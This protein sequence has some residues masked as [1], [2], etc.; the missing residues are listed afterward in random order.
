MEQREVRVVVRKFDGSRHW[1]HTMLRL[2]EDEYGVWLGA[3]VG[4]V[5]GK[6]EDPA[7][8]VSR[9]RRV[10]L[11]PRDTWWTAM[12][13]EAPARLDVYCDVTTPPEWVHPGEVTTVDL[14][15]DVCRTRADASVQVV[16]EDEFAEHQVRYGYP[17]QVIGQAEG[18]AEWLS[19]AL[20]DGVE[21]FGSRYRTW[22]AQVG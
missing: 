8:Y 19:A 2:G 18:A 9:E 20:R 21:P 10:M 12:F 15:L 16:D 5:Y 1:H 3:P 4:T 11:F 22:L 17:P 6:G 14:D 13:Q 7:V